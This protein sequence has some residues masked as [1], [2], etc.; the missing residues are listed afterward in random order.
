MNIIATGKVLAIRK[1][2]PSI[3]A[4]VLAVIVIFLSVSIKFGILA[5][6][7]FSFAVLLK[8]KECF[9]SEV[10]RN[11]FLQFS[12]VAVL[13]SL[14]IYSV[15][16]W[17]EEVFKYFVLIFTVFTLKPDRVNYPLFFDALLLFLLCTLC[18]YPFLLHDGRF[19]SVLSHPNHLAYLSVLLAVFNLIARR[20]GAVKWLMLFGVFILVI[21]SK[22]SGGLISFF[23]LLSLYFLK[24]KLLPAFILIVIAILSW[25][26]VSEVEVV[27]ILSDKIM[28][29]DIFEVLIK[30]DSTSFGSSGSFVWRVSYWVALLTEFLY[31]TPWNMAF[32]SG[33]GTMSH[34]NYLYSWMITDPHNDYVRLLLERGA[35]GFVLFIVVFVRFLILSRYFYLMIPSVLVPMLI[36]NILTNYSFILVLIIFIMFSNSCLIKQEEES[37]APK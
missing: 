5:L 9:K 28:Q 10:N 20:G 22:S 33:L 37:Y 8:E 11:L 1:D 14:S 13:G 3:N 4:I 24:Q 32:G 2:V 21:A 15:N 19:S 29:F 16:L 18:A 27:L 36:G 26:I 34:G 12:L 23:A 25:P 35:V 17:L 6:A 31:F 7:A 30:A